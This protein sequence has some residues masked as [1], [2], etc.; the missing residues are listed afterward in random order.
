MSENITTKT[1]KVLVLIAVT[2]ALHACGGGGGSSGGGSKGGASVLTGVFIDSPVVNIAYR[3]DSQEGYTGVNG[4]YL[5]LAGETVTFSI[6]GIELPPVTATGV[7]TPLDLA[8]SDSTRDTEVLNITRL[9][10]SLDSDSGTDG[11]QIDDQAHETT[12]VISAEEFASETFIQDTDF[13]DLLENGG[14]ESMELVDETTAENH[15]ENS[16]EAILEDTEQF[17]Q[18][19]L[20]DKTFY[21]IFYSSDEER[22]RSES[23]YFSSDTYSH[24]D[25]YEEQSNNYRVDNGILVLDSLYGTDNYIKFL[26]YDVSLS[27]IQ[28]CWRWNENASE[29]R[30]SSCSGNDINYM[31]DNEQA[32]TEF[33]ELNN[34]Q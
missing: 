22:W 25:E 31:F 32:A 15:L 20:V 19:S 14:S 2:A 11:I 1:N 28:N 23:V 4:E 30:N 8:D 27:A 21:N 18:P 26:A 9:L 13:S 7:I 17:Y 34:Q 16:I 3:T 24:A 6:A 29:Q 33:Q 10:L 12:M 5:Y